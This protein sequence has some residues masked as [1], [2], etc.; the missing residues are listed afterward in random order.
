M[1][2][3][4]QNQDQI[5][6][7]IARNLAIAATRIRDACARVHRSPGDVR[8]IAVT[9]YHSAAVAD[10]LVRCGVNDIG[11]NRL[12]VAQPKFE[13]MVERPIRHFIGPLQS[14][15]ARGV[16]SLFNVL[17]SL[18]RTELA[19]RLNGILAETQ[20]Q[21]FPCFLQV[22]VSGEA[23]KGGCTPEDLP[24]LI[25]HVQ[26]RCPLLEIAGLMTMPPADEDIEKARPHFHRL[27]ELRDALLP[28][29][30]LS[31]GMSAD[32]TVAIEEGATH[33]RIGSALFD[34]IAQ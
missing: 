30:G 22:N 21:R 9:K 16:L 3:F 33:V 7:I 23:Q 29:Q 2:A 13:A 4:N 19:T 14:N 24:T 18:D 25:E 32:Y 10:V 12:Q 27:R 34:G 11:E 26:Q 15:K 28:E 20:Q 6:E 1:S 31:M 5:S 8:L 17:H